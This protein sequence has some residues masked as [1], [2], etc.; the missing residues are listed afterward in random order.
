MLLSMM[1]YDIMSQVRTITTC[2][3]DYIEYDVLKSCQ[4]LNRKKTNNTKHKQLQR[5][6]YGQDH[7]IAIIIVVV[8][9]LQQRCIV[10]RRTSRRMAHPVVGFGQLYACVCF[11]HFIDICLN[12]IKKFFLFVCKQNILAVVVVFVIC[13]H[14]QQPTTLWAKFVGKLGNGGSS[15]NSNSNK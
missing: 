1:T 10:S 13:Y 5:K 14:Y 12:C 4:L 7:E 15:S 11:Q 3:Y 8:C 9:E 2:I 6:I